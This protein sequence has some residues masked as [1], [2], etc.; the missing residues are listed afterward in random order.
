MFNEYLSWLNRMY[1]DPDIPARLK[2]A[3][4]AIDTRTSIPIERGVFSR[5]APDGIPLY[6]HVSIGTYACV[7]I[8]HGFNSSTGCTT[9]GC[10]RLHVC[11]SPKCKLANHKYDPVLCRYGRSEYNEA[12]PC[13]SFTT[14]GLNVYRPV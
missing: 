12:P 9:Q 11:R 5:V 13:P 2:D 3:L 14:R 8:C 10:T 1:L 4:L 7:E 6:N